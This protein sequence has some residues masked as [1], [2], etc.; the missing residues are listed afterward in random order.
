MNW[1]NLMAT[2]SIVVY[3]IVRSY[4]IIKH[5]NRIKNV[6]RSDGIKHQTSIDRS[7]KATR[8]IIRIQLN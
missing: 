2:F 7:I 8:I 1:G 4:D 3:I 6:T 5:R